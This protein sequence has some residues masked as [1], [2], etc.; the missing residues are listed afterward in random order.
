MRNPATK[1]HRSAFIVIPARH[2]ACR[3]PDARTTAGMTKPAHD[4]IEH[5]DRHPG[6]SR[7][8]NCEEDRLSAALNFSAR[9]SDS[10]LREMARAYKRRWTPAARAEKAVLIQKHRPWNRRRREGAA[11]L[12]HLVKKEMRAQAAWLRDVN[13]AVYTRIGAA[14]LTPARLAGLCEDGRA[15]T[16]RLIVLLAALR[17]MKNPYIFQGVPIV[18]PRNNE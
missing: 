8:D 18:T 3:D 14:P 16:A 7:D 15:L 10:R 9:L 5:Q 17:V 6:E 11:L 1:T 13:R 4:G 12:Y 2:S